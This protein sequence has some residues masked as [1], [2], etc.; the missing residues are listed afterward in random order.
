[1]KVVL[2]KLQEKRLLMRQ[3]LADFEEDN[4]NF[5]DESKEVMANIYKF[6]SEIDRLMG[7]KEA[8]KSQQRDLKVSL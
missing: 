7:Q 6:K 2:Q 5:E 1:M 8:L 3:N 4:S